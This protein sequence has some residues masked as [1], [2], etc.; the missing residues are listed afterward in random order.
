[1]KFEMTK[2]WCLA[3]AQLESDSEVAAGVAAF[4]PI[5]GEHS[6]AQVSSTE[7]DAAQVAFGSFV[8]LLRRRWNLSIEELAQQ[9]DLD[10]VELVSI[11]KEPHYRPEPRT[12]H[13]LAM[14]F[15]LPAKPLLAL[16]GNA[17]VKNPQF[18]QEAVRFAAR[19]GSISKLTPEEN[20]ALERFVKFLSDDK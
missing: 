20:A 14:L 16:S 5:P 13:N 18:R 4:D 10:L 19:A 15:K 6:E 3:M 11:E 17:V 1:M 12:V 8:Q 7:A 9:A 2:K